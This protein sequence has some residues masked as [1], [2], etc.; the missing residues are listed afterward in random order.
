MKH[1]LQ[2]QIENLI[3]D[4]MDDCVGYIDVEKLAR[5]ICEEAFEY[6][7]EDLGR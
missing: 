3:E 2:Q 7:R 5:K 1:Y 6:Y 4:A